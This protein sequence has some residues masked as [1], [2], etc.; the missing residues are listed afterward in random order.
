MARLLR[1]RLVFVLPLAVSAGLSLLLFLYASRREEEAARRS[2]EERARTLASAVRVSCD[3]HLEVLLS[4][5]ALLASQPDLG[6]EEFRRFVEP[7]L[8]R[9]P[10]IRGLSWNPVVE[11]AGRARFEAESGLRITELDARGQRGPSAMHPE[12]VVV[13]F[14]EPASA[15]SAMGFNV[16]SEPVR[17]Q[18]LERARDTGRLVATG[19]IRLVSEDGSQPNTLV[20]S[21]VYAG[22]PA[23]GTVELRRR[24]VRGYTTGAFRLGDLLETALRAL[25]REGVSVALFDNQD[26]E[27]PGLL[28]ADQAWTEDGGA[29]WRERIYFAGRQWEVRVAPTGSSPAMSWP[30]R[31]I[32][33]GGLLFTGLLGTLL[34]VVTSRAEGVLRISEARNRALVSHM[35]GGMIT[36]D[37]KSR[38]ESVNPAAEATFGYREHELIGRSVAILLADAPDSGPDSYLRWAHQEAIGRVS[39]WRGKRKNGEVFHGEAALFEFETPEGR[40]FACNMQDISERREVD[41]LKSEFVSTVSHELRT[42]LTSIRGALGLLAAG[43]AGDTSAQMR[44]LLLL[45]ERNVVRLTALINDILDFD[46]LDSGRFELKVAEV[47]LQPLFDQA[48]EAVRSV[49]REQGVALVCPPTAIRLQVDPDRVVQV[50]LNLLSNAIKFSPPGGEVRVKAG[51]GE[52]GM[53]RLLVEDQGPGIP[54]GYHQRIFERFGQ[55]ETAA[56]RDKGGTG[57]GLAICKA[58]VEHHGGRIGVDTQPGN[59]STFWVDLPMAPAS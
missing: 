11:G 34:L 15:Q 23:P 1:R 58:I 50:L 36:F 18:A 20:F 3:G 17:L 10:G 47:D 37:E 29:A 5:N 53:A 12:Y 21:P 19:P 14:I 2:F 32:L 51:P 48:L 57:L 4:L 33:L 52:A 39:Q 8:R 43:V 31:S 55:V 44:E 42:P 22:D 28:Y 6:R 41:R 49:A 46:R 7:A 24:Q 16:A 59:G 13:H 56:H 54:E 25:P 40:R 45:A 30:A 38:I 27:N 35:I 26:P 9:H